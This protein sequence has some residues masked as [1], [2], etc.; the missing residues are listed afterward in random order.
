M[1]FQILN[2][3]KYIL[4]FLICF[5]AQSI[6]SQDEIAYKTA[7]RAFQENFNVQNVNAVFN[8]YTSEMQEAMTKEGVKR[9]VNGC[10]EQFGKL[11]S[12]TFIETTE[13]VNSYMAEFEKINLTM[14]L[15]LNEN[16]K[17][18]TIQFQEP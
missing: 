12:L 5:T 14:E 6:L 8:L 10:Y 16:G 3:M 2:V 4:L 18:S 13:G 9:F 1:K 7:I 11:K 15:Q 17:I